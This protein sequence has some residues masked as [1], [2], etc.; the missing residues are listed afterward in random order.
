M[1]F[2]E[3]KTRGTRTRGC[4]GVL[5]CGIANVFDDMEPLRCGPCERCEARIQE[6]FLDCRN[7]ASLG[8]GRRDFGVTVTRRKPITLLMILM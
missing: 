2:V 1:S 4:P 3:H 8:C 7:S 5:L 6:D